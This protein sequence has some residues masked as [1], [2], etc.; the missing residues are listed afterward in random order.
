MQLEKGT[1]LDYNEVFLNEGA[2]PD[3]AYEDA[4]ERDLESDDNHHARHEQGIR[5]KVDSPDLHRADAER[6]EQRQ[7]G[8]HEKKSRP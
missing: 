2:W 3:K 1:L 8:Q 7:S 4:E 5:V 6:D